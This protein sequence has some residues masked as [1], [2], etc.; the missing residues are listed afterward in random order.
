[1]HSLFDAL[2]LYKNGHLDRGVEV[3]ALDFWGSVG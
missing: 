2:R 1:M 3:K